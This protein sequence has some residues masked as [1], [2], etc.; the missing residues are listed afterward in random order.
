MSGYAVRA[1]IAAVLLAA[2]LTIAMPA[3][4][5][6]A[7]CTGPHYASDYRYVSRSIGGTDPT[8]RVMHELAYRHCS[9]GRRHWADPLSL[10]YGCREESGPHWVVNLRK[11][12]FNSRMWDRDSHEVNPGSKGLEC[13]SS[14]WNTR[15]LR[16]DSMSKFHRC[17]LG[18]PRVDTSVVFDTA[19]GGNPTTRLSSAF[20][21][22]TGPSRTR[23]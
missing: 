2:G 17:R 10:K 21:G 9:E 6:A 7:D 8:W 13:D 3:M 23:C 11:V 18:G 22:Y 16:F 12:R 15:T 4:A 19:T 1:L 5:S 14:S 20:W